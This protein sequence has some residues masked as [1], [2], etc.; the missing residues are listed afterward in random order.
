MSP[1]IGWRCPPYGESEGRANKISYCKNKCSVPCTAPHLLQVM[2]DQEKA[3]PHKGNLISV[4]MLT[5]GCK[6]KVFLERTVDY[7]LEPDRKL[8]TFRGSLIHELVSQVDPKVAKRSKWLVEEHM[9]L[10]VE[11]KSGAWSLSAT[12]DFYEAARKT[13]Y[14]LKTLQDYAVNKM[15][16]GKESGT[17]SPNIPDPYVKQLN[18]YRY[19]AHELKRF[20]VNRLRLQVIGFGR[21]FLT[22]TTVKYGPKK[23]LQIYEIPDVPILP[24]ATVEEWIQTEGDEWFRILFKKESAP[25]R[26]EEYKWLC[27][28][29]PF[30]KSEYCPDPEAE[31][32]QQTL[33]RA[34]TFD[35]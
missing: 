2:L 27:Y 30:Y 32:R 34:K 35:V 4:T 26:S 16:T 13:I 33:E 7:Y 17:W 31:A 3:N 15:I 1:L 18:L 29:C 14:D 21:L 5:G 6:R 28:S 23:D 11:T 19:M 10:P 12:I 9:E 22:G 24:K 20:R 25:V 8:P